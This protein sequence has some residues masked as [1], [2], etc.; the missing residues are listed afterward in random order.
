MELK[1]GTFGFRGSCFQGLCGTLQIS[2]LKRPTSISLARLIAF[3]HTRA[4]NLT[5]LLL[6]RKG[7]V[8]K[9]CKRER[10]KLL[11]GHHVTSQEMPA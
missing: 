8:I 7:P 11:L 5:S 2:F 4:I 10:E 3:A 1:C 9:A 6:N